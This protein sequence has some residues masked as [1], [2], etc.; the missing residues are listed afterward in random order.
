MEM[1]HFLSLISSVLLVYLIGRYRWKAGGFIVIPQ[2][3]TRI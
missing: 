1:D 2:F 3:A